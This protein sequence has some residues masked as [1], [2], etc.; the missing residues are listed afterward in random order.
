M[1]QPR[2]RP[3]RKLRIRCAAARVHHSQR[4]EGPYVSGRK[5]GH[6]FHNNLLRQGTFHSA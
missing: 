1:T 4:S 3:G 5:E 2:T 6:E